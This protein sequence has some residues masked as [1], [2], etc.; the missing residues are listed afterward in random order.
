MLHE[1]KNRLE[2]LAHKLE[3][4]ILSAFECLMFVAYF[5]V[6][7]IWEQKRSC[8]PFAVLKRVR[9]CRSAQL[10]FVLQDRVTGLLPPQAGAYAKA[11]PEAREGKKQ[12]RESIREGL[13]MPGLVVL[14]WSFGLNTQVWG[15]V[16]G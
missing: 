8:L 2:C 1:D 9:L 14:G 10:V 15:F 16:A 7:L 11:E 3:E 5:L 13:K 4:R 6:L 12:E